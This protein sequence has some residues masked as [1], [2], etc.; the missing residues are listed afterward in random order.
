[1]LYVGVVSW[2]RLLPNIIE[3]NPLV[4][5]NNTMTLKLKIEHNLHDAQKMFDEL[6]NKDIIASARMA[7][8]NAIRR[9]KS[10]GSIRLRKRINLKSR[11]IK[12][13]IKEDKAKGSTLRQ[14][15][16]SLVFSGIPIAMIS[17]LTKKTPIEQKGK[18]IKKR[19][20]LRV[21]VKG[22]KSIVLKGAFIQKMNSLQVFRHKGRG[23]RARKLSTKS[24]AKII[25]EHEI[26]KM[27]E[28][29]VA[30]RFSREF[31]RQLRWRWGKTS[32]KYSNTPMKLP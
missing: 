31:N 18:P 5:Y 28:Q 23:R 21:R 15:E 10:E 4:L 16:A 6:G 11:E 22:S 20:K 17:F 7:L 3:V 24:L 9:G 8:N 13:R 1:M 26:N 30:V 32:R 29:L 2:K 14:I 12:A 19:R 25:I 27:L